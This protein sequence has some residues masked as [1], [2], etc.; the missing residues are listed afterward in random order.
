MD[1][2]LARFIRT[3]RLE[4]GFGKRGQLIR[5]IRA[6]PSER[7]MS[8]LAGK[9]HE[10]ETTGEV[11]DGFLSEVVGALGISDEEIAVVVA[12]ENRR[13]EEIRSRHL[14]EWNRWADE[15]IRPYFL[16]VPVPGIQVL[17]RVPDDAVASQDAAEAWATKYI[18]DGGPRGALVWSR[19]LTVWVNFG[20]VILR[21]TEARPGEPNVPYTVLRGR[22]VLLGLGEG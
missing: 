13:R 11:E 15:P 4:R 3:K 22:K 9:L 1:S 10:L 19:R 17:V 7:V 18:R 12:A 16:L 21:R 20:G 8:R 2:P 6:E 5:A 14:A